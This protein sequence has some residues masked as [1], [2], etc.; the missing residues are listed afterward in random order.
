MAPSLE[1]RVR[2]LEGTRIRMIGRINACQTLVI[3]ALVNVIPKLQGDNLEIA[4]TFRSA[5]LEAAEK[6]TQDFPGI[7]PATLDVL[8][9]E[10][11]DAIDEL[12][13]QLVDY[14]RGQAPKG[15]EGERESDP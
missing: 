1:D 4:E 7:D 6:P 15:G 12:S 3:S 5:W 2:A 10:Y 13:G 9:Q 8:G 11:R 14:F